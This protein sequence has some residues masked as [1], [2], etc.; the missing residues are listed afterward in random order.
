MAIAALLLDVI[1]QQ[2]FAANLFDGSNSS[3]DTFLYKKDQ[4]FG[5]LLIIIT[6][7]N[8]TTSHTSFHG[9]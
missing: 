5:F 8:L 9:A 7:I 6:M 2:K 3:H 4:D 1:Q